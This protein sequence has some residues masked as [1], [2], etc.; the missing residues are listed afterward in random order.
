MAASPFHNEMY[1]FRM[2][3]RCAGARIGMRSPV[4]A[5]L[6]GQ[7]QASGKIMG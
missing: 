3:W 5:D 6:N 2:G 4:G 1:V 7:W